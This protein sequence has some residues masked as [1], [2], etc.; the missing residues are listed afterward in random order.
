MLQMC[1]CVWGGGSITGH[2][3]NKCCFAAHEEPSIVISDLCDTNIGYN[4]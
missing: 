2:D 3:S 1:V 4:G